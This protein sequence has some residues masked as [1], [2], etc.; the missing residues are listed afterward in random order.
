MGIAVLVIVTALLSGAG[1]ASAVSVTTY[2]N[3]TLRTGWNQAETILTPANVATSAFQV[4]HSIALDEQVDAQPLFVSGQKI[5][6]DPTPHDVVY[7]VTENNTIYAIDAGNGA[8]LLQRTLAPAIPMSQLPGKCNNN[9]ALVGITSTP[10]IDPATN[11]LYVMTYEQG[12]GHATGHAVYILHALDASHLWHKLPGRNVVASQ[13]LVSGA[14]FAFNA[15][16]ERQRS[17]LLL[18]NGNIYAGFASFCDLSGNATRGW[19]LGWNAGTLQP[20]AANYLANRLPAIPNSTFLSSIWMSGYGITADPQGNLLFITG[21]TDYAGMSYLP[22]VNLAESVV[23]LSPDLSQ[24]LDYFTPSGAKTGEAY[25]DQNDYDFGSG[26]VLMLPP[27]SGNVPALATAMG[28]LGQLYL[29][30]EQNLGHYS[31]SPPD[32]NLATFSLGYCWCGESYFVGSDN[33]GRVVTSAGRVVKTFK[34]QTSPSPTLVAETTSQILP[35]DQT[36]GFFTSV[37]SNATTAGTAIVWAA[38]RPTSSL[39]NLQLAAIDPSTGKTLT[40]QKAGPW[41]YYDATAN[42]VPVVAKGH[43]FLASY[44]QLDI[45]GLG[46][47]STVRT[48]VATARSALAPSSL[49]AS[50]LAATSFEHRVTGRIVSMDGGTISLRRRDGRVIEVDVGDAVRAFRSVPLAKDGAVRI[51][52]QYD[53]AGTLRASVIL[54]AGHEE[55][56]WERDQ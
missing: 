10:V 23:K 6:D 20:L 19:I 9:S 13:T 17:A 46:A 52:G 54:H 34:V 22:T 2:H 33:V 38:L 41:P 4:L 29:L 42:T 27:Q 40:I 31:G 3:D 21:N 55:A 39:A 32:K 24:V 1:H 26:G 25:M 37:S 5:G 43:V 36:P 18:A 48:A 49:A 47:A 50:P 11:T 28:K 7:V 56:N 51:V 30:N 53:A 14:T 15:D 12:T 8:I 16:V 44:K 35:T 45:F